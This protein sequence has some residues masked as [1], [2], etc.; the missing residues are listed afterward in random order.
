M[1][2][3]LLMMGMLPLSIYANDY[4]DNREYYES[5]CYNASLASQPEY[6]AKCEG[7]RS[8]LEEVRKQKEEEIKST[9]LDINHI[10]NNI[11]SYIDQIKGIESQV[12]QTKANIEKIR[13]QI[14]QIEANIVQ[15]D[16]EIFGLEAE[17]DDIENDIASI[18]VAMQSSV[19]FDVY[20]DFLMAS[21]DFVDL[22]TKMSIVDDFNEY[23]SML[24]DQRNGKL[25]EINVKRD[26]QVAQRE[27]A[28][29]NQK[30]LETEE[31]VLQAKQDNLNKIVMELKSQEAELE[32]KRTTY[33][34]DISAL[35][36]QIDNINFGTI[37]SSKGWTRPIRG[38]MI[39]A[40]TWHYPASFGGGVHLGTDFAASIGTPV[41]AAAN[42]IVLHSANAC[43]T[44]GGLGSKCGYPGSSG[45][46]NQVYL[47][48][49]ISGNTYV[50]KYLHL[51][52]DTVISPGLVVS[53]GNKI[54]ELGNSGNSSGPH[55]HVEVFF[56][57]TMSIES[58]ARSWDGDLSFGAGWGTAALNRRC[59]SNGWSA[60]CRIA[61]QTVFP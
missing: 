45:G 40:T 25:E 6:K 18:M 42:G 11:E 36:K 17:I 50:I 4:E 41:Y 16:E 58:Y 43:P 28:V 29:A 30:D 3:C 9:E 10:K 2:A 61:P 33:L 57:G 5:I 22:M 53:A 48:V 19:Y 31:R 15:I 23:N 46:G 49:N 14:R 55:V 44:N 13:G 37:P 34:A 59:A 47:L 21:N 38:G 54:A 24:I 35:N 56:V 7:Y 8:Y 52:K 27:L 39:S 26:A 51:K 12:D 1:L 32:G 20:L 60:P